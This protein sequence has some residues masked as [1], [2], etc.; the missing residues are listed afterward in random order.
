MRSPT[1]SSGLPPRGASCRT[2]TWLDSGDECIYVTE[3]DGWRH[4][5]L[6]DAQHGKIKN[7][8]TQGSYVVRGVDEIDQAKRQVWFRACGKNAGDDPYFIHY[9]RVNFDGTGLVCTDRRKR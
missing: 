7:V 1:R 3:R 9:Y 2:V 4:L 5:E 8:I 6:I